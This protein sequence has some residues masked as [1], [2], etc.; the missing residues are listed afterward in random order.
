VYYVDTRTRSGVWSN[1][2]LVAGGPAEV[3]PGLHEDIA[4]RQ[5]V[6]LSSA[7]ATT[8][9]SA[10]SLRLGVYRGERENDVPHGSGTIVYAGEGD[11][12]A[13]YTGEWHKGKRSGRGT[14]FWTSGDK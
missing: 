11:G 1:G 14:M 10:P 7:A 9:V 6:A 5:P 12:A 2:V 4:Q 3:E 8:G 13:N